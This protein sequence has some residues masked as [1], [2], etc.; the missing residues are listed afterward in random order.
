MPWSRLEVGLQIC[1]CWR[2]EC[3][4]IPVDCLHSTSVLVVLAHR[5][6]RPTRLP[7]EL[8]PAFI[9]EFSGAPLEGATFST[10]AI[11]SSQFKSHDRMTTSKMMRPYNEPNVTVD[12]FTGCV[13]DHLDRVVCLRLCLCLN[14]N[15]TN[16]PLKP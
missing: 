13:R 6:S 4:L 11:W 10:S 14:P 16:G 2:F 1:C 5:V 7:V 9:A 12:K 15:K 3:A 8:K